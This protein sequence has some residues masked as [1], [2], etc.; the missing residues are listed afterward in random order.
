MAKFSGEA[1]QFDSASSLRKSWDQTGEEIMF[2]RLWREDDGQDIAEYAV[3]RSNSCARH[4]HDPAGNDNNAVSAVASTWPHGYST[5][6]F[7]SQLPAFS[8]NRSTTTLRLCE[9]WLT[10]YEIDAKAQRKHR[11]GRQDEEELALFRREN[12][13]GDVLNPSVGAQLHRSHQ[14][15]R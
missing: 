1:P 3:M 7:H 4:W 8:P 12:I 9:L 11:G 6:C 13:A 15:M 10:L 14:R 5:R 2:A